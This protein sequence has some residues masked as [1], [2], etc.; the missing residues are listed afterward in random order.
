MGCT[1]VDD[2]LLKK[3]ESVHMKI[4]NASQLQMICLCQSVMLLIMVCASHPAENTSE[5]N[6]C[7]MQAQT[8]SNSHGKAIEWAI[9][10]F[11]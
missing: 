7:T 2:S 10:S 5:C 9:S 11:W 3:M 6:T 8:F 1:D 4:M